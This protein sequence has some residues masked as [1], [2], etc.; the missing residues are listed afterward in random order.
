M[1][2]RSDQQKVKSL[3]FDPNKDPTDDGPF[4]G[5]SEATRK[6][7]DKIKRFPLPKPF[8]WNP[9]TITFGKPPIISDS[10]MFSVWIF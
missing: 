7:E 3:S 10:K 2:E 1:T 9:V 6:F 4:C 8:R 5:L